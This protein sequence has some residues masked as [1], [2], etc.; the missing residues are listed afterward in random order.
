M[1]GQAVHDHDGVEGAPG[2]TK[3]LS[4]LPVETF[5]QAPKTTTLTKFS[6]EKFSGTGYEIHMGQTNLLEGKPM[7][8]ILEQNSEPCNKNDGC[9]TNDSRLM[10]TYIHGL[11]D[12]PEITKLWLSSVG[13]GNI[14]VSEISG[15]S[16]RDKE[17]DLLAE[18][19]E[20][21]IDTE[22]ILNIINSG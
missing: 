15:L 17:Y 11:L 10:G 19:F 1:M 2:T 6:W 9:V 22:K 12:T 20:K 13:L 18:H 5:L 3:G 21:H 16:A 8:N 7:L 14:Q 4:I